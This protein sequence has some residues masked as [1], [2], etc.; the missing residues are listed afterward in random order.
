MDYRIVCTEQE[1]AQNPPRH[2]HI[3]AVGTG[4][5]PNQADQRLTLSQV[6]QKMDNGDRFYTKGL[7]SGKTAWVE[8]YWCSHCRKYHIRSSPDATTDNNLDNL[9]YCNWKK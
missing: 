4:S 3:V 7:Q 6:I 8:K 1:P 9:R 5:N 2:A